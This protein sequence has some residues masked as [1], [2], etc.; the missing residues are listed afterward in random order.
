MMPD[1]RQLKC[2]VNG[3]I[4]WLRWNGGDL[5]ILFRFHDD[6]NE[7][8]KKIYTD[9]KFVIFVPKGMYKYAASFCQYPEYVIL[10]WK[11]QINV[12]SNN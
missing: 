5:G 10:I 2:E 3:V 11:H 4:L 6:R 12:I 7:I 9:I 1:G 8:K